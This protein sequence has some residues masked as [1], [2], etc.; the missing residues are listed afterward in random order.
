MVVGW[1]C[2]GKRALMPAIPNPARMPL[3]IL[4]GFGGGQ[5]DWLEFL[6]FKEN[7]PAFQMLKSPK[8][9]CRFCADS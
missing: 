3:F 7:G 6:K 5:S 2:G 4:D 8:E 9:S 1:C